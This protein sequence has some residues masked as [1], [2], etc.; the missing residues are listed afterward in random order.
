MY[1]RCCAAIDNNG[2]GY[3]WGKQDNHWFGL[4]NLI[5]PS[6][7]YGGNIDN[8][9]LDPDVTGGE[10]DGNE[11]GGESGTPEN[12]N[13][14]PND[15]PNYVQP[16][17]INVTKVPVTCNLKYPTIINKFYSPELN[18]YANQAKIIK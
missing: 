1:N 11:E 13:P 6:Q 3:V 9:Y 5:D 18:T 10:T 12:E 7:S 14:N 16:D 17:P 15:S 8:P 4:Y 2:V